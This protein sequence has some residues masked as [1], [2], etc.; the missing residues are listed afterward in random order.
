MIGKQIRMERVINRNTGCSVIV[1]VDHGLTVGPIPG[2]V[3]MR[4]T[5]SEVVDGGIN[6]V[7]MHKGHVTGGHRGHGRDVGLFIHL[8][9]ATML[10]PDPNKKVLVATVEEAIKL[11]ADGISIHINLGA[12][13]ESLMLR[14]FGKI[15]KKCQEWGMPLLAMMYTRGDKVKNESD[16][17]NVKLAARVAHELGADIVKV[18]F[19]GD[20]ESFSRVTEGVTIP[21]L[22]AGGEKAKTDEDVL[23]NVKAALDGGGKGVSIGRNVF[24]HKSPKN[25]CLA[26]SKL[27]HEKVSLEQALTILNG[28]I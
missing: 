2:L 16:V 17:D 20:A 8:S 25:F 22:I 3:N 18:T 24:Q 7:L 1:P 14:D 12:D 4:E 11:G 23:R 21:V 9:G 26:L 6:A 5:V 19:T 27:V 28:S 15:G 13:D 10:A